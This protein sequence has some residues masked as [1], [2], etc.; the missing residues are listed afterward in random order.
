MKRH[1]FVAV[2]GT[3][4]YQRVRPWPLRALQRWVYSNGSN[5]LWDK[6]TGRHPARHPLARLVFWMTSPTPGLGWKRYI[7]WWSVGEVDYEVALGPRQEG[8]RSP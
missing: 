6:A 4:F 3:I 8:R 1:R 2:D 7:R 5:R